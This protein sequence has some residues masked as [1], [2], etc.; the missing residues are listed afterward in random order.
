MDQVSQTP[1]LPAALPATVVDLGTKLPLRALAPQAAIGEFIHEEEFNADKL[2]KLFRQAFMPVEP[3]GPNT[4]RVTA[5]NGMIFG[6]T[7][8]AQRK[9]LVLRTQY[10]LR[11][12][13]DMAAKLDFVNRVNH[14]VIVIRFAIASP[15][16]LV[17][18]FTL[19]FE[20][21]VITRQVMSAVRLLANVVQ[22]A[23]RQHDR[24]NVVG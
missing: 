16:T 14:G 10:R 17:A 8:D 20:D 22:T 1:A 11:E 12:E 2:L 5:D 23:L 15:Q 21:G 13:A 18:D 24:D 4:L 19:S 3:A 9:H 7:V 6:A